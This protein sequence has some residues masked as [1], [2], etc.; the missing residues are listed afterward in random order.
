MKLLPTAILVYVEGGSCL[1]VSYS[2]E[3]KESEIDVRIAL[4]K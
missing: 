4:W 3:I 1:L 2:L